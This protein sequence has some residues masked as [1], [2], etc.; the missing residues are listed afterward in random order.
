MIKI[1]RYILSLLIAILAI[2]SADAKIAVWAIHPQY[3]KINRFYNDIFSYQK[4]GKYG[5]ITSDEKEILEANCDFITGF[6]GGYAIAGNYVKDRYQLKYI[7]HESGTVNTISGEYYLTSATPYI[8]EDKLDVVDAKGKY[9]YISID[10]RL[11]VKCQ[12]DY[13]LPFK[14]GWASV[15]KGN[16]TKYITAGYDRNGRNLIVNFHD[17]D[18]TRSSCFLNGVAAVA[19]NKDFALINKSGEKVR[20]L[21]EKNFKSI[22]KKNNS[23][24]EES[25][26]GF[27]TASRYTSYIE[28]GKYGLR[29]GENVLVSPQFDAF[30]TEYSDGSIVVRQNGKYGL[31]RFVEGDVTLSTN[32][33][34]ISTNELIIERNGDIPNVTLNCNILSG[35]STAKIMVDAGNGVF[36]DMSSQL[37]TNGKSGTVN[38]SPYI[39]KNQE[40]CKIR[41]LIENDGILLAQYDQSYKVTYPIRLRVSSPGPKTVRANKDDIAVFSSTIYNDS[42]KSVTVSYS[43]STGHSGTVTIPAHSSKTVSGSLTVKSEISRRISITLNSGESATNTLITF[44]PYW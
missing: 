25:D 39:E 44:F 2:A 13:A 10:G 31:M 8:S 12:F 38:I 33:N 14:E 42:P 43:W 37:K 21:S 18:M 36:A 29:Q 7:I 41:T 34:G 15:K 23:R 9:G 3:D 4:N 28:N 24:E 40:T 26:K 35:I 22:Y 30:E 11:V 6:Y 20:S 27:N 17:G 19:Y 32:I 1:I 5:L 16:Y